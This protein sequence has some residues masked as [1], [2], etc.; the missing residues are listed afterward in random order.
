MDVFI[1]GNLAQIYILKE[2]ETTYI[3]PPNHYW[4]LIINTLYLVDM[5]FC[6]ALVKFPVQAFGTKVL[7]FKETRK[8][9][10]AV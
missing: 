3:I 6:K 10:L 7:F 9:F 2:N 8:Q 5:K 1:S 4:L